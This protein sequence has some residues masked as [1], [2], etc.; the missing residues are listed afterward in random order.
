MAY[1]TGE[2]IMN[3]MKLVSLFLLLLSSCGSRYDPNMKL[4]IL[5]QFSGEFAKE[6]NRSGKQLR[7][8]FEFLPFNI[9][10][11]SFYYPDEQLYGQRFSYHFV[12]DN[13]IWI[14]GRV[15]TL[16][17]VSK[18]HQDFIIVNSDNGFLPNGKYK[19]V[20]FFGCWSGI[21]FLILVGISYLLLHR[22]KAKRS[23]D[24]FSIERKI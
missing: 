2:G 11:I 15:G 12:A 7:L 10:L 3:R 18:D 24:G 6:A 22:A 9:L 14:E 21:Y 23:Y 19:R 20:V 4:F 1:K 16:I 8:D 17:E 5:G 13:K